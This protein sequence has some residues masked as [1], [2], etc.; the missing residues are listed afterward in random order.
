MWKMR[1][2]AA[3]RIAPRSMR[4]LRRLLRFETSDLN[5]LPPDLTRMITSGRFHHAT[6]GACELN[7]ASP[8][9]RFRL[10]VL[11]YQ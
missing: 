9:A 2:A 7:T 1:G 11:F 5:H 4:S 3:I 8:F 6:V 10:T